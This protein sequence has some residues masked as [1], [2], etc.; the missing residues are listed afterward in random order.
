MVVFYTVLGYKTF[1]PHENHAREFCGKI[2]AFRCFFRAANDARSYIVKSVSGLF[3]ELL[4]LLLLE[5]LLV[6]LDVEAALLA[7]LLPPPP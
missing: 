2:T 6:E 4:V 3:T 5:S 7:W 1:A